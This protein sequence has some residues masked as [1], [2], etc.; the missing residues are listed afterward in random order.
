[1]LWVL[2]AV[3]SVEGGVEGSVSSGE[4]G[5]A[6]W[7]QSGYGVLSC[8]RDG[9]NDSFRVRG[10]GIVRTSKR[11]WLSSKWSA[12]LGAIKDIDLVRLFLLDLGSG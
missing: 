2:N 3:E 7:Q 5:R 8:F 11:A 12:W 4:S 10:T 1:M 6:E 9:C